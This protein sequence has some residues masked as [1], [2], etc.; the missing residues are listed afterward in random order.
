[1]RGNPFGFNI[2]FFFLSKAVETKT[3]HTF[4]WKHKPCEKSD[5]GRYINNIII[6]ADDGTRCLD[7]RPPMKAT[8]VRFKPFV[9]IIII[10]V[11][12]RSLYYHIVIMTTVILDSC[13]LRGVL[14]CY[15]VSLY[16]SIETHARSVFCHLNTIPCGVSFFNFQITRIIL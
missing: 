3:T 8:V 12:L 15:A 5:D 9:I 13:S 10:I 1:M 2:V 6:I 7:A 14:V 16:C 4:V 11:L